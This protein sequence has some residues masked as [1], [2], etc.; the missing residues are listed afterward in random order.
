MGPRVDQT[1]RGQSSDVD[2]A[3]LLF[4]AVYVAM[5]GKQC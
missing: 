3:P 4:T 2:V 5:D 1:N